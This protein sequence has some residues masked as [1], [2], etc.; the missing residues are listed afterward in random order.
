M[1]LGT[2]KSIKRNLDLQYEK[3]K[4]PVTSH[5]LWRLIFLAD[6]MSCHL[7]YMTNYQSHKL[8]IFDILLYKAKVKAKL[9]GVNEL[10]LLA[11]IAL[12]CYF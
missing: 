5:Q 11:N 3:N 1:V 10:L 2:G 9:Y 12:K 7:H 4:K 8:T 6:D